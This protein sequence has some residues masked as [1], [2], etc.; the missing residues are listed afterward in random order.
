MWCIQYLVVIVGFIILERLDSI[1]VKGEANIKVTLRI[2]R[3]LMVSIAT[4][5][6]IRDTR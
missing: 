3:R 5:E 6:K 2:E 4:F 1:L